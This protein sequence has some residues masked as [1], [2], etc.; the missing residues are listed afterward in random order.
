VLFYKP[1]K[2]WKLSLRLLAHSGNRYT[3]LDPE[4]PFRVELDANDGH[5]IWRIKPDYERLNKNRAPF[6]LKTDIRGSYTW[7]FKTW[8]LQVFLELMNAQ[9]RKNTLLFAANRGRIPEQE[10]RYGPIFELPIIP[11]FGVKGGF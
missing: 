9:Y 6:Y 10:P 3:P 8:H 5:P 7:L 1:M 4:D 2:N 11:F